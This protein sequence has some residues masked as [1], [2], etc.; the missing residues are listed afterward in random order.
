MLFQYQTNGTCRQVR[1]RTRQIESDWIAFAVILPTAP[2]NPEEFLRT[3]A[4]QTAV[5]L[6]SSTEQEAIERMAIIL[7]TVYGCSRTG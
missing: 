5:Q 6:R 3:G 7:E 1:I 4:S 2:G